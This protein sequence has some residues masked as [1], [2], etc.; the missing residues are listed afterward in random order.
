MSTRY[1][2]AANMPVVVTQFIKPGKVGYQLMTQGKDNGFTWNF[3]QPPVNE[4]PTSRKFIDPNLINQNAGLPPLYGVFDAYDTESVEKWI[5]EHFDN[6][7]FTKQ[8]PNDFV[9]R[10][11]F[12]GYD[13]E[14]NKLSEKTTTEEVSQE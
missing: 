2:F 8:T 3:V 1:R 12:K 11:D 4:R 10:G 14:E 5:H 7:E 9:F 13:R 6:V